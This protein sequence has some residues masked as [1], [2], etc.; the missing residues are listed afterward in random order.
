MRVDFL[1]AIGLF[2]GGKDSDVGAK[3]NPLQRMAR[4]RDADIKAAWVFVVDQR[5]VGLECVDARWRK[6]G[7]VF[8][9]VERADLIGRV[10]GRGS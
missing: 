1:V 7:G 8:A 5:E 6:G 4:G 3:E 10:V 2:G 9:A